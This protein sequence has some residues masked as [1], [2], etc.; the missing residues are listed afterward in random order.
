M[1]ANLPRR[2]ARFVVLACLIGLTMPAALCAAP[3][4]PRGLGMYYDPVKL[5]ALVATFLGWVK[6][7]AWVDVDAKRYR[8]DGA[9]WNGMLLLAG[10][11]GFLLTW[12]LGSFWLTSA[13]LW[14]MVCSAGYW[15]LTVRN[16]RAAEEDQ[17]LNQ[18]FF[19]RCYDRY[20]KRTKKE[21]KEQKEKGYPI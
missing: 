7:C 8:I 12:M 9:F 17:L 21:V 1:H 6:L 15:Y 19:L 14:L 16:R 13:L 2:F 3:S 10:M 20:M 18:A 11:V 4:F 5:I